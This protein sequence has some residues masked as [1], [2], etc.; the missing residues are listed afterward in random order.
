MFGV[1]TIF[2]ISR[3]LRNNLKKKKKIRKVLLLEN[4]LELIFWVCSPKKNDFGYFIGDAL[5]GVL[6]SY[7]PFGWALA[8]SIHRACLRLVAYTE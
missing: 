3:E 4:L 5:S 2:S 8:L 1:A 6:W 7:Y